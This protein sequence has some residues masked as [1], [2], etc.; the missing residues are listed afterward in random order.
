[1]VPFWGAGYVQYPSEGQNFG[2]ELMHPSLTGGS[3]KVV[4]R[5]VNVILSRQ[6]VSIEQF[7][8]LLGVANQHESSVIVLRYWAK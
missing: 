5:Y 7:S 2:H 1:M 3:C 4:Y 6:V 8:N